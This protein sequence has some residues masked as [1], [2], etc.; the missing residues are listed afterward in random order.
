MVRGG[1]RK[2]KKKVMEFQSGDIEPCYYEAQTKQQH[3]V[4]S[5]QMSYCSV[6]LTSALAEAF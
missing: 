2:H 5:I 4:K 6:T 3:S 1:Q